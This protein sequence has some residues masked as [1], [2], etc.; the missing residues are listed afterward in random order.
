MQITTILPVSRVQYL[1]RVLETLNKQTHKPQSLIVIFD[2]NDED[3]LAVRN[4]VVGQPYQQVLCVR[5]NNTQPAFSIPER[6][7][8]IANIHNQARDL[9][10][11]ADWVF[12][13]EDDGL[14]PPNALQR[15]VSAISPD[16]GMVTG[17]ELGRWG[18]PYVGAWR[19]DDIYNPTRVT[20]MANKTRTD[21]REEI[22]GCGLYCG[23]IRA[24]LYKSHYFDAHNGLGPDVNLGLYLRQ[25]GYKNYIDWGIPVTHL[26]NNVGVEIEIPAT[27][28]SHV[29]ALSLQGTIWH[30]VKY[31]LG[32][33]QVL[34]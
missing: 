13:V 26:T 25:Q 8:H 2:G 28:L 3:Y 27:D 7:E 20:S 32:Y 10:G 30:Q 22:D 4:K 18:V 1:D 12:S 29:V 6:R 9:I 31:P 17:V 33:G 5:S 15:L 19:V 34:S 21:E 23:L 14:L 11:D 24:N 16:I